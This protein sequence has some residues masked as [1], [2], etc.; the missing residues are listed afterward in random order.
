M[1]SLAAEIERSLSISVRRLSTTGS[2]DNLLHLQAGI[3][4]FGFH[5]PGTSD[6]LSEYAPERLAEARARLALQRSADGPVSFVANLYSQPTHFFVHREAG[7]QEPAD[8]VG[9]RV[10]VGV[11]QSADFAMSLILLDHFGVTDEVQMMELTYP[12]IEQGFSNGDLDAAFISIGVQAPVFQNIV[13]IE[14]TELLSVPTRQALTKKY[15]FLYLYEIPVG[16]YSYRPR[17]VPN[18]AVRTVAGGA[19]L[20]S[21]ADV[22]TGLVEEVTR[23]VLDKNF[24]RTNGLE[25]LST[26][27]REFALRSSEF[28]T[29]PG[30]EHYYDPGLRP[31]LDSDF[32]AA[33]EDIRIVRRIICYRCLL[34]I[35]LV[36]CATDSK[37]KTPTGRAHQE[38]S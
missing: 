20:L 11:P 33:T 13:R 32:V 34:G 7:I 19:L 37:E 26:G 30:A 23:L 9:K 35:P 4:D 5:Q 8:L 22:H 36:R 17:T 16:R 18:T 38:S 6:V 14:E 24:V 12:E 1:E 27:G 25:E 29:H 3:A 10:A 28:P 15:P 31:L 21:R 2:L